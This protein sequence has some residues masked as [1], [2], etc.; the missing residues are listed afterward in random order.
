MYNFIC[1]N[2]LGRFWSEIFFI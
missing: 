2:N 1:W